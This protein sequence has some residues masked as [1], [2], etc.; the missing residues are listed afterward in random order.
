MFIAGTE[1]NILRKCLE[2]YITGCKPPHCPG[3]HNESLWDFVN[4]NNMDY[5]KQIIRNKIQTNMVDE[6]WILGGEPLDQDLFELEDLI[7]F[8]KQYEVDIWLWTKY[9]DY[10]KIKF[11]Y[12]LDYIKIGRYDKNLNAYM[13]TVNNIKLA[14]SNQKIIK[15]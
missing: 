7:R 3:C 1:Y 4:E 12:L 15:L 14:S 10:S 8:I 9:T 13:D 6:V 11:L 2:I 5:Y